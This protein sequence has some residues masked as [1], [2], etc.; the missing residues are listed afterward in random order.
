MKVGDLVR[1]KGIPSNRASDTLNKYGC[2]LIVDRVLFEDEVGVYW[3]LQ[4]CWSGV[5]SHYSMTRYA[6]D[7]LEM[8][9][10]A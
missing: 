2:G 9:S 10:P 1:L 8:V 6:E 4:V 3:M 7:T 5:N